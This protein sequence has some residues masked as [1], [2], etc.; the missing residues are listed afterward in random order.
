MCANNVCIDGDPASDASKNLRK[1]SPPS[2]PSI[3]TPS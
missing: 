2:S 3:A 1:A